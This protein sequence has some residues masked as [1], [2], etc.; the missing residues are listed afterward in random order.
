M[1]QKTAHLGQVQ[2][3]VLD[4][5][6]RMLDMG[7]LPDLQRILN[8]LPKDRQT[9]LFSA[10]FSGEIKKLASTY[11]NN[12]QTIEVARSKLHGNQRHADRF[13]NRRGAT[14]PARWSS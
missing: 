12:P 4:E 5:A 2:I 14:R 3:L 11:L 8:L 9:L 13:R 7:F 6:D 10:T 1:Q